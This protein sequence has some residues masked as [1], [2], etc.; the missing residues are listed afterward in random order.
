MKTLV[1]YRAANGTDYELT[2]EHDFDVDRPIPKKIWETSEGRIVDADDG[3][4]WD[5][6]PEMTQHLKCEIISWGSEVG[7]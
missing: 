7:D 2:V 1:Q 5:S 3:G 4:Y 6:L